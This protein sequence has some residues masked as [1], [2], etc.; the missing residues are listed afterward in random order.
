VLNSGVFVGDSVSD[1][2]VAIYLPLES[3]APL[4]QMFPVYEMEP[5]QNNHEGRRFVVVFFWNMAEFV[6]LFVR[7]QTTSFT[8]RQ[9]AM[10]TMSKTSSFLSLTTLMCRVVP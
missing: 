10:S 8:Y 1:S 4:E 7:L 5:E 9:Q 6:C 3:D 2:E